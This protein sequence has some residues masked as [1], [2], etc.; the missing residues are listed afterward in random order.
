M[1]KK[2]VLFIVFFV[3]LFWI[4]SYCFIKVDMKGDA[5]ILLDGTSTYVE[6]GVSFSFFGR[7]L[8]FKT[9]KH[10]VKDGYELIYSARNFFGIKRSVKRHIVVDDKDAP[11]ITLKG[12]NPETI[13]EGVPYQEAGYH[14]ED[15]F[16]GDLSSQVEVLGNVDHK[17]VG[18]YEIIYQVKDSS[19]NTATCKRT[20]IVRPKEFS[21]STKYDDIDNTSHSWWSN[22]KM[23]YK[24]P[25]GGGDLE[26]LK[27]YNAYFLGPDD[28][29]IYLTFD[30]GSLDTYLKEI[31]EVLDQNDV[32]ATIFLC[33]HYMK[34]NLDLVK[35][36]ADSGHSIGNHTYHH[37]KMSDYA[38][39][40]GFMEFKEEILSMEQMYLEAVGRPMDK[41][42]RDPKGEWSYRGLQIV[43]DMGYKSFF[44]S[45]DYLDWDGEKTKEYALDQML[46]KYHNGAIYLLHP[47]QKGNLEALQD[48]IQ[49]MKMQG[50]KFGLV[51]DIAY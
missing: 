6:P 35:R 20:V 11:I 48:F 43:K 28:K 42:Y 1:N 36:W 26:E 16:D 21:Y 34:N 29:T 45:A 33:G 18:T 50:Y 7:D 51:K 24:R 39:A 31:V 4:L 47:K 41:V 49:E 25:S 30:E 23:D 9:S 10:K 13:I 40:S 3:W 12:N 14:A 8:S 2:R 38:N 22:N 5:T 27:K 44:W 46:K 32:K 15:L 19:L 17:K 37:R